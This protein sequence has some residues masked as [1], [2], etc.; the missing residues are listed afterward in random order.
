MGKIISLFLFLIFIFNSEVISQTEDSTMLYYHFIN[1]FPQDALVYDN[2]TLIGSTP[3]RIPINSNESPKVYN[4]IISKSGYINYSFSSNPED[5]LIN[6]TVFLTPVATNVKIERSVFLNQDY[7]FKPNRK[8]IPII[9]SSV[10]TAGSVALTI[11]FK[12][13]AN[14]RYDEYINTGDRSKLDD[15]HHYDLLSGLTLAA[16][17]VGFTGLIYFLFID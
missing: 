12:N 4:I 10:I 14:E 13:I 7:F 6:K 11:Y 8:L 5:G 3:L 15:T 16:F 1:S 2:D 17:Q 9:C